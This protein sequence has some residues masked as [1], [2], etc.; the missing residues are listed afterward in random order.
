MRVSECACAYLCVC[1][2]VSGVCMRVSVSVH[3]R[4][5]ECACAYLCVHAH[6]CVCMRVSVCACILEL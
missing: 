5:C 4:I 2:R 1:M 6:I 3:A